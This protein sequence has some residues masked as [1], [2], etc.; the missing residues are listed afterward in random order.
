MPNDTVKEN[1][2][3]EDAKKYRREML[4]FGDGNVGRDI[5]YMLKSRYRILY[6]RSSEEARVINYFKC[7]SLAEGINL[8]HWDC[9]R[10]LL[11]VTSQEQVSVSDSEV[12]EDPIALLSYI[13][14]HAK[15]DSQK[16][17]KRNESPDAHVYMLLDFHPYLED[18]PQIE[19]RMKDFVQ[20]PSLC[21]IVI[22]APIFT[23]P[24]SLNK[25]FTLID[26]PFPSPQEIEESLDKIVKEIPASYPKARETAVTQK[27]DLI[28]AASG[29]TLS[30][31]ENA[32]AKTLVKN[33][34]FLVST[35]LDEK[36]QIIRKS[37][38][39]EYRDPRFTF[40]QVGGLDTLREWLELHQLAF[41]DDAAD[42]GLPAPKGVMLIGIPG[43]GKSM[44]CEALASTYQMPLLRLDMGAIF[45]A[46]VGESEANIRNCIEVAEAISPAILWI[47]EVEKG[48]GGVASSNQTDGGVTNRVFGTLLTWM[49]DKEAPVFVVCTANNTQSIPPE[50]MRAGRFDEIFFLDIPDD[51]QRYDVTEKLLVRKDRDP[52]K[53]DIDAIVDNSVNYTPVEIE[54]GINNALFVAYSEGKRDLA[55]DDIVAELGKFQ[56]LYNSR[57]EDIKQMREWALGDSG[58]GGRAVLGNSSRKKKRRK[59]KKIG[60]SLDMSD[61]DIDA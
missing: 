30:E 22:V 1:I 24:P 6:I 3:R 34:D 19:R 44:S 42:F 41:K 20:T 21:T 55:T 47:D 7:L 60:R 51:D 12:H 11:D 5:F 32:F 53:F 52:K 8:F 27:E 40:D 15:S 4:K 25:E 18:I 46:H 17:M 36:K 10:G 38:I 35:V 13:V 31:V 26:F 58:S 43:T 54:K 9:S 59:G 48:I 14:D 39:L 2:T 23:C 29:L 50:F 37:G 61:T 33:K 56:P 57:H 45:G 49:Q 16:M 28:K